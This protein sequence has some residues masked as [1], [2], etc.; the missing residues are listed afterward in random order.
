MVVAG[1]GADAGEGACKGGYGC[2][3]LLLFSHLYIHAHRI[4]VG[5]QDELGSVLGF[6]AAW[7]GE[8]RAHTV[9]TA[10]GLVTEVWHLVQ[11]SIPNKGYRRNKGHS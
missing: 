8:A 10:L 3:L 6:H 4:V 7:W 9:P 5:E 2:A 1:G 11:L